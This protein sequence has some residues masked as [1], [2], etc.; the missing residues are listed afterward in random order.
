MIS[1]KECDHIVARLNWM[2][3]TLTMPSKNL[4]SIK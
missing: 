2:Y 3:D 4:K 1:L